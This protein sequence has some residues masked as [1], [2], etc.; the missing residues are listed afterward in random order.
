MWSNLDLS[1]N[2]VHC[3]EQLAVYLSH[4]SRFAPDVAR[5]LRTSNNGF[6]PPRSIYNIVTE[7]GTRRSLLPVCNANERDA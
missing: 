2:A 7:G 3:L 5:E 1:G 6:R 4:I